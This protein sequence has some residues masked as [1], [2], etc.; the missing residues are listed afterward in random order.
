MLH[1]LN[2]E[3]LAGEKFHTVSIW[4]TGVLATYVSL[5]RKIFELGVKLVTL[6]F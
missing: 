2:T 6:Y 4:F 3:I 5:H 1:T